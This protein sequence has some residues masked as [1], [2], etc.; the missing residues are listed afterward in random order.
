M[1]IDIHPEPGNGTAFHLINTG[2]E[3]KRLEIESFADKIVIH[4]FDKNCNLMDLY[5]QNVKLEVSIS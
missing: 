1:Y 5:V 4:Q 3:L 2:L